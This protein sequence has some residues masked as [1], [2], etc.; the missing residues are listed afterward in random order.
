MTLKMRSDGRGVGFFFRNVT[1]N[2][3]FGVRGKNA[4]TFA[5]GR[6][7]LNLLATRKGRHSQK[8]VELYPIIEACS[9]DPYLELFARSTRPN[10]CCWG[11]EVD[12]K[13]KAKNMGPVQGRN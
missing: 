10:W 7:Q 9:P 12:L 13:H 4:R 1:E 6:R 5:P 11:D 8:P 2:I 3:L